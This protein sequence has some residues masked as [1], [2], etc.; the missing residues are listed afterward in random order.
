MDIQNRINFL[1][2]KQEQQGLTYKERQELHRLLNIM[3]EG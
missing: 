1:T 2:E 3:M